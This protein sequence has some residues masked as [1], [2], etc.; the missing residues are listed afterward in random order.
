MPFKD[1]DKHREQINTAQREYARKWRTERKEDFNNH[2]RVVQA[3]YRKTK[4]YKDYWN[5]LKQRPE[6]WA[7]LL[8]ASNK[9]YHSNKGKINDRDKKGK[10]DLNS[11]RY[12]KKFLR[13]EGVP[14][15]LLNR[16]PE[17]V[18]AKRLLLNIKRSLK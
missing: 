8:A 17:I 9:Y 14:T 7:K 5:R 16:Y 13:G 12:I 15:E 18:E 11:D 6:A 3:R 10:I 2:N 1:R 4:K